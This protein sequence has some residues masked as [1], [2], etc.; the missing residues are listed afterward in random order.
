[1]DDQLSIDVKNEFAAE[2]LNKAK[3]S[4]A[5]CKSAG[6]NPAQA[7]SSLVLASQ[8]VDPV[9]GKVNVKESPHV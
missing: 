7:A 5:G 6:I 1:M 3:A 4:N 2:E 8:A 9:G